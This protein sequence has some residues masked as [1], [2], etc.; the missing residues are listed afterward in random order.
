MIQPYHDM[1][2]SK[3]GVLSSQYGQKLRYDSIFWTDPF[4]S[5][6]LIPANDGDAEIQPMFLKI[7]LMRSNAI[8]FIVI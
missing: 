1:D 5:I 6:G 8:Y 7:S 2:L 4:P 3:Y